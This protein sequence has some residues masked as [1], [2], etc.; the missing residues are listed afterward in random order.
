MR[1]ILEHHWVILSI[2]GS[3]GGAFLWVGLREGL[4]TRMKIGA[5]TIV[6]AILLFLVG[7]FVTTPTE[8]AKHI[9]GGFVNAVAAGKINEVLS[10][11]NEEVI[12]V[13]DWKG[14]SFSGHGGVQKSLDALY[15]RYG[16]SYN[17]ILRTEIFERK[18]DVLVE[19]FLF[20]R[21]KGIGSV[22][23]R[24]R[25]LVHEQ[26]DGEWLIYS[27]DAVEIAGRSYR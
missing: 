8:H 15:S 13:D 2:V 3:I 23:S 17:T 27:I 4:I 6:F 22:P 16:I 18:N 26:S 10:Y 9:I 24:W 11:V 12:L 5:V 20:S 25:I 19:L 21:V 7:L 14:E 1:L